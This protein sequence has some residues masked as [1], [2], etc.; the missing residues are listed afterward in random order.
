[1][2]RVPIRRALSIS[3]PV[4]KRGR[5]YDLPSTSSKPYLLF[6]LHRVH[7]GRRS[8]RRHQLVPSRGSF[9]A[10]GKSEQPPSSMLLHVCVALTVTPETCVVR[11][12][13]GIKVSGQIRIEFVTCPPGTC[14]Q[15]CKRTWM[16]I[17]WSNLAGRPCVST[18]VAQDVR[19][20]V[21]KRNRSMLRHLPPQGHIRRRSSYFSAFRRP[22]L[23]S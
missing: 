10:F 13:P 22:H 2:T 23:M 20:V 5:E 11:M 15:D 7:T 12:L 8:R 9:L 16:S 14:G 17:S 21:R 4:S 18:P 19:S 3:L 1:M 6:H